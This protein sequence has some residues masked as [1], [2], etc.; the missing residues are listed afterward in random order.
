LD[1]AA[2]EQELESDLDSEEEATVMAI[3]ERK[4]IIRKDSRMK[5]TSNKS[6]LPREFRNRV[7]DKHTPSPLDAEEIKKKMD[8]YGVDVS[9]MLERGRTMER[10]RKRERSLSRLRE[11]SPD[12]EMEDSG[13]SKKVKKVRAEERKNASSLSRSRS[14]PREPSQIGLKDEAAL[15]LTKQMGREGQVNWSRTHASGEGDQRKSAHL[16]KWMNTGKKR[17]GT[18]YCR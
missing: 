15:K 9:K 6:V 10:G 3:R 18:H 1:A 4:I 12:E 5:N 16:I 17:N 11:P 13:F 7:K 14:R 8:S 2:M